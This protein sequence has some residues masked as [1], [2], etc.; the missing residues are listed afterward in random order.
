MFYFLEIIDHVY[1]EGIG[2][3][4]TYQVPDRISP[5]TPAMQD[6]IQLSALL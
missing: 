4:I 2:S 1:A 5:L 6:F 3:Y